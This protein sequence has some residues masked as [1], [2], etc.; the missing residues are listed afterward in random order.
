MPFV[1]RELN[2]SH[3]PKAGWDKDNPFTVILR[4]WDTAFRK[5][6]GRLERSIIVEL[7]EARNRWAHPEN[8]PP[9]SNHDTYRVLDSISR[10]LEAIKAKQAEEARQRRDAFAPFL[11][12]LP[13][14]IPPQQRRAALGRLDM[15]TLVGPWW[16]YENWTHKKAIVHDDKCSFC[17]AGEGIHAGSSNRNGR[18]LGPF[19]TEDEATKVAQNTKQTRI[20]RC[21]ICQ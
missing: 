3:A 20:D 9:F 19:D 15:K 18:W 16:V 4:E 21:R 11:L 13:P 10:L 6:L 5:K 12:N 2:A 8:H 17:N 14:V 7:Q 1:E